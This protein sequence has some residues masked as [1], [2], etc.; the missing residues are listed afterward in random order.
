MWNVLQWGDRENQ[1]LFKIQNK[2]ILALGIPAAA[3][4]DTGEMGLVYY[5]YI[6]SKE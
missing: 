5:I 4:D 3:D 1:T 6:Y 2:G